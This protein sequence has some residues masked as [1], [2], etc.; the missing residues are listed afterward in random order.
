[1]T[2]TK[3][4]LRNGVLE[5]LGVLAPGETATADD[6]VLVEAA[7]DRLHA[8]WAGR[9]ITA[10]GVS[11][12]GVTT[13]DTPWTLDTVPDY[14]ADSYTLM[15]SAMVAGR[16]GLPADRRQEL[17]LLSVAAERELRAQVSAGWDETPTPIDGEWREVTEDYGEVHVTGGQTIG[18]L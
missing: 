8:R 4:A 14:A 15:C 13:Y 17:L 6:A 18:E 5:E 10:R 7:L 2:Y 3:V 12:G 11:S 1:M 16:F 9:G